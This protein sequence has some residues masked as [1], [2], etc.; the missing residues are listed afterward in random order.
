MPE[1]PAGEADLRTLAGRFDLAEK[2]IRELVAEA[3]IGGDR[4]RLL[5]D[6]PSVLLL[7]GELRVSRLLRQP[8]GFEGLE[9]LPRLGMHLLFDRV[10]GVIAVAAVTATPRCTPA[11]GLGVAS[12]RSLRPR[13]RPGG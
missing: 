1:P 7:R 5:T 10:A 2:Q 11:Y 6:V 12:G 13:R 4:R 8:H 9:E 3:T